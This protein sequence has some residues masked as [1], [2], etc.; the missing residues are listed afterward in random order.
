MASGWCINL[1]RCQRTLRR[2]TA[3]AYELVGGVYSGDQLSWSSG[4]M[5]AMYWYN[6]SQH[7][8]YCVQI[9]DDGCSVMLSEKL[10]VLH[11]ISRTRTFWF[12]LSNLLAV[13][14]IIIRR[15]IFRCN[16][17]F[18]RKFYFFQMILHSQIIY[19]ILKK[20]WNAW[21]IVFPKVLEALAKYATIVK[22]C[23]YSMHIMIRF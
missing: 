23:R 5:H 7:R 15:I 13:I 16:R 1:L 17:W 4:D 11:F 12:I 18:F 2:L 14:Y 10:K 6:Q 8:C 3:Q 22:W 20:S 21:G 19:Y 9:A